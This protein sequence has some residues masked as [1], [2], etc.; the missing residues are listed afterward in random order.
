MVER[1]S[2]NLRTHHN[3]LPAL[4]LA[5]CALAVIAGPARAGAAPSKPGGPLSF[6]AD[7]Y[8]EA[9]AEARAKKSPLF[10]DFWAPW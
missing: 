6:V 10:I 8:P 4:A 2:T 1:M 5:A 9:L 7:G 3:L